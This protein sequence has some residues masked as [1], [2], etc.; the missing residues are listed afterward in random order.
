MAV[1][2]FCDVYVAETPMLLIRQHVTTSILMSEPQRLW[3]ANTLLSPVTIFVG[4]YCSAFLFFFIFFGGV[5]WFGIRGFTDLTI[6]GGFDPSC[7]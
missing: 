4:R 2:L 6:W 7:R 5:S 1:Y 3:L